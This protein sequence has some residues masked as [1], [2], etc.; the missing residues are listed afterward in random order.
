MEA[1]QLSMIICH[2]GHDEVY[3][4]IEQK[5]ISSIPVGVLMIQFQEQFVV[6]IVTSDRYYSRVMQVKD[7][8]TG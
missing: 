7:S 2:R 1:N 6:V 5:M 4:T 8:I 3:V